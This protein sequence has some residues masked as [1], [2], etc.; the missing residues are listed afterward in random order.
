MPFP[1]LSSLAGWLPALPS[2][3]FPSLPLPSNLQQRLVSF[4]LR[5]SLGS[6]IK[7][8]LDSDRIEADLRE[9]SFRVSRVELDQQAIAPLLSSSPTLASFSFVSGSINSIAA[10][11]S[12]PLA[13]LDLSLEGLEIVLR[14]SDPQPATDLLASTATLGRPT[15][16][17]HSASSTESVYTSTSDDS[18]SSSFEG[19]PLHHLERG[20]SAPGLNE[21]I[22]SLAVAQDFISHELTSDEDAELRASL[23]LSPSVSAADVSLP[24]AFGG[25]QAEEHEEQAEVVETTMLAAVIERILARLGVTVAGVTVR[26]VWSDE[27]A[28]GTEN[29]L[30]LRIDEASYQGDASADEDHGGAAA[31]P[32]SE[33]A[34][35]VVDCVR[36]IRITPPQ[37]YLWTPEPP[38]PPSSTPTELRD[39]AP[40]SFLSE[41][42][43][44]RSTASFASS[45]ASPPTPV[46]T[47]TRPRPRSRS[48][49]SSSFSSSNSGDEND[50]LAMSQSIADLRTSIVST[51]TSS[52]RGGTRSEMFASARSFRT[53]REEMKE[54]M[55]GETMEEGVRRATQ[56]QREEEE[57]DPFLDPDSSADTLSATA[58]S[59]PPCATSPPP[60]HPPPSQPQLILSLGP[61]SSS[62]HA[63]PL[64]F[65][66]STRRPAPTAPS[67]S[68]RLRPELRLTGSLQG[69]WTVALD[70]RQLTVLL[71]LVDR[72]TPSAPQT[73][74]PAPPASTGGPTF[75]L[76]VSLKA[77]TVLLAYPSPSG[78][79]SPPT[80]SAFTVLP[81]FWTS[82]DPGTVLPSAL[83]APHLRLRLDS[84]VLQHLSFDG[85]SAAA[86]AVGSVALTETARVPRSQQEAWRT[87][88]LIV[89]DGNLAGAPVD[90][91]SADWVLQG[92]EAAGLG[93]DWRVKLPTAA[94]RRGSSMREKEQ[95]R[96]RTS[97]PAVSA[98]LG[99]RGGGSGLTTLELSPMHVFL[100]LTL[101][102]R[103]APLLDLLDTATSSS[104]PVSPPAYPPPSAHSTPRPLSPAPAPLTAHHL[105]ADLSPSPSSRSPTPSTSLRPGVKLECPFVR[106]E[107]RCPAPRTMRVEA[108]EPE[109]LRSGIAV[110]ELVGARARAGERQGEVGAECQAVRAYLLLKDTPKALPFLALTS[111]SPADST[112]VPPSLVFCAPAARPSRPPAAAN[113]AAPSIALNLPLVHL[114]LTKPVLD[115]LQLFADDVSQFCA[116]EL[117]A[118]TMQEGEDDD[119][120]DVEEP[121]ARGT[122]EKMI[123]SRYFGAK[124]FTRRRGARAD[125]GAPGERGK[126]SETES[127]AS[128]GTAAGHQGGR[129][130]GGLRS[131]VAKVEV[132]DVVVDLLIDKLAPAADGSKRRHLRALASDL[133]AQ[134][135]LFKDSKDD[136]RAQLEIMD[137][138]LEDVTHRTNDVPARVMLARTLPRNLTL[139]SAAPVARLS[140]SSSVEQE[141][142]VKESK[143]QL[144]LSQF[145]YFVTADIAWMD[146]LGAFAQAPAGAFEHVVPNELT[147][148][149]LG[150][151]DASVHLSAPTLASHVVVT[152]E[153]ARLRTDLMPDLPRTTLGAEIAGLRAMAVED[154]GDLREAKPGRAGE[155]WRWW[156]AKGFVQL[157]EVERASVQVKQGNGL[158]LP[159]F[160]LLVAD[161]KAEVAL[162]ADSIASV[163]AFIADL[164]NAPA[165]KAKPSPPSPTTTRQLSG[166]KRSSDL[167]ASID[168]AAFDRAPSV[169]DLPEILTDDVPTNLDYLAEA[170]A[171]QGSTQ[172]VSRRAESSTSYSEG[173]EEVV[174]DVDGET[175]KMLHPKGLQIVDEWLAEPRWDETDYS[176]PA[177]R[178]RCRLT[179]SDLTIHLHE[180]YDWFTT[181][182]TIEE[183]AKAVRRR[184]EKIR[185]LLAS[186]QVPDASAENASVLMFGSHLLGLP[187]GASELPPKDLLA[188]INEEL[189]DAMN[190][191]DDAVSTVSSWQTLP[192]RAGGGASSPSSTR[193]PAAVVVG[194][195]RRRLTRSKAFA[196]ELNVR[197]LDAS[198]DAYSP[199]SSPS[200]SASA[201]AA[202][203][204]LASKV[205][206]E[207]SSFDIIDNIKTST[208]RKFLTELRPSDGGVVRA[209][210]APMARFE[211]KTVKPVG[212]IASAQEE[213]VMKIKISPLRLYIDQDAL[214]FLKAFGAFEVPA[215]EQSKA[216][217]PNQPPAAGSEPF[218]QRVEVLPVKLK[219]DYK[220]KRVDYYALKQGKTAELMNFFHFDGSEMT[221]RHLVV[222]GVS[223]T[224]TLSNLVQDIW[225]PDVKANQL[226]D[227]ISGITHVRSVVNVSSGVANLVLLPI[228][229]Y[230]KDGR[231][232]RGLQKGAQAFARQTTLEAINVGAKLA[233]GTQVILE[234]AEHVLGA[235][236]AHPV[237][238]E[239]FAAASSVPAASSI[240]GLGGDRDGDE[241]SDGEDGEGGTR[242][243]MS[244]YAEQP[245]DLRR[246]V[247][248][249]YKSLGEN[250]KEAAQ[251]ILAVPMEVYERSGSEGPVRAVVRAVPIAVLKP[252]IGASGAVSK[253]LLGLRNT[254]DPDAQQG[255]LED[256]YK[257]GRST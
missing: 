102:V 30:E 143:L 25:A 141:T 176:A 81:T 66:L 64:V 204:Q 148:I 23:H 187:P 49:S 12:W 86:A 251:T 216:T 62:P 68:P 42:S 87:L 69:A 248:S 209:S 79:P 106:I 183:E 26:V 128:A 200:S 65:L 170:L 155:G 108:R 1:S 254:L 223:G 120:D 212:S 33:G 253:A 80:P 117:A 235:R 237:V 104:S 114:T 35:D 240:G 186:G 134:I 163:S 202:A 112:A 195:A 136:L 89:S 32:S 27:G 10:Q 159:D 165:F 82:R 110:V 8:G 149:R 203:T 70:V 91:E 118:S 55:E 242:K 76:D 96:E 115:G 123:G 171:Q 24:G 48:S 131:L 196:I 21:S 232:V 154:E 34:S 175:I 11:V 151:S 43:L 222:T 172:P 197:G 152:L 140:F 162:C 93:R 36:S 16:K 61:S 67:S 107:V 22:L 97:L 15:A 213:I 126:E 138:K 158:V 130:G 161:A 28:P 231:I 121:G 137:V 205:Q 145:T 99:A 132:T 150:L 73:C 255:E 236:F 54:E 20:P 53:V 31:P 85:G 207:V 173:Q 116:S 169:H 63:E 46:Q 74:T 239:M 238:G 56:L 135:E 13:T 45:R 122:R 188:A 75:K 156:K 4:L 83:K 51:T 17:S 217:E 60:P 201:A 59:V 256:K 233:T 164:L 129:D 246:G 182:K 9:G 14:V 250:F 100:D 206:A 208:W 194:K 241:V 199:L 224:T 179:R 58:P 192:G 177:S 153:D 142:G 229:Q 193:R 139:P 92:P 190:G 189:D 243:A 44:P 174:S 5:K 191:E 252:M 178:I 160:E 181:R 225:T 157:L 57:R 94:R 168:P 88:P 244:R 72:I 119:E 18:V 226:A 227:V 247:E 84:L 211:L 245:T 133:G 39:L 249:A 198:Y 180:G 111:L 214:D 38:A 98:R 95:E 71:Q 127:S 29:E 220:P 77:L 257:R 125:G 78:P 166:R 105:L 215:R 228:E 184:L 40:S 50:L 7:G 234:Q 147:R 47:H 185:Q 52:R 221:L 219:L 3:S 146:E 90:I 101:C 41:S 37:V 218:F 6:F 19:D 144:A 167:L 230:R 113:A 210:G 109:M 124:S 2:V 103:L